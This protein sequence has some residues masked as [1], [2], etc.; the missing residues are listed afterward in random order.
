MTAVISYC[1]LRFAWG[2]DV[3][4]WPAFFFTWFLTILN[5]GLAQLAGAAMKSKD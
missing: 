3:K 4:S 1:A 5:F 2:L